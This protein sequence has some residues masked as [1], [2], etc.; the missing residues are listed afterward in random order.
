MSHYSSR[1]QQAAKLAG[2][3]SLFAANQY[4]KHKQQRFEM[5]PDKPEQP[6]CRQ[7][8][9]KWGKQASS[10]AAILLFLLIRFGWGQY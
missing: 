8:L 7:K 10:F 2:K 5:S 6:P 3:A 9:W 1:P 4:L